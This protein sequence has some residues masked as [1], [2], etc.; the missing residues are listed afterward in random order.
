MGGYV[1]THHAPASTATAKFQP[2]GRADPDASAVGPGQPP[3]AYVYAYAVEGPSAGMFT[4]RRSGV[5]AR[6]SWQ[7]PRASKTVDGVRQGPV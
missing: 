7:V 2:T 5:V 3:I 4:I 6:G 1:R